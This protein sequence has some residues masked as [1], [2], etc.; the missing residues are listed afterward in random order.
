MS[1]SACFITGGDLVGGDRGAVVPVEPGD[2]RAV[3][4]QDGGVAGRRLVTEAAGQ[5]GEQVRRG[6]RGEPRADD[7]GRRASRRSGRPASGTAT[8][9]SSRRRAAGGGHGGTSATSPP[10]GAARTTAVRRMARGSRRLRARDGRPVRRPHG[11]RERDRCT[12]RRV[13]LS[14][15]PA[16]GRPGCPGGASRQPPGRRAQGVSGPRGS[17]WCWWSTAATRR[18]GGGGRRRRPRRAARCRR[19]GPAAAGLRAGAQAD[20]QGQQHEQPDQD[21]ADDQKRREHAQN[22][23]ERNGP[24]HRMGAG[25]ISPKMRRRRLRR[26]RRVI[27]RPGDALSGRFAQPSHEAPD[28]RPVT[29]ADRRR[30]SSR[31]AG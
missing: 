17:R 19:C 23:S 28:P 21:T 16:A 24:C 6:A 11:R 1:T 14:A 29:C 4:G 26:L 20:D 7:P 22:V 18:R 12:V 27:R 30:A 31:C 5:R 3:G 25:Q 15:A 9:N 2:Q 10:A 8:R 13:T